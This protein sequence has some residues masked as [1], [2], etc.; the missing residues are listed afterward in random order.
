MKKSII[1]I[2]II[3]CMIVLQLSGCKYTS[4]ASTQTEFD[5]A[6]EGVR[7]EG[8]YMHE[9]MGDLRKEHADCLVFD[10][11]ECLAWEEQDTFVVVISKDAQNVHRSLRFSKNGHLL[12]QTEISAGTVQDVSELLHLTEEEVTSKLGSFHFDSGSGR[13]LPSYVTN[14]GCILVFNMEDGVVES[15]TE[16]RIIDGEINS[17]GNVIPIVVVP[18]E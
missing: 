14:R 3:L 10:T 1:L 4:L 16:H 15:I 7:K 9:E 6:G 13:Y 5:S 18:G 2:L 17:Y 8:L 12:N 11:F